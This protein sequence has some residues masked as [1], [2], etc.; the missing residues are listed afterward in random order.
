LLNR[1]LSFLHLIFPQSSVSSSTSTRI[2]TFHLV[3]LSEVFIQQ[4]CYRGTTSFFTF[5]NFQNISGKILTIDRDILC[6][7]LLDLGYWVKYSTTALQDTTS[8]ICSF[9]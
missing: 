3:T 8:Y 2:L 1:K 5:L 7:S 9:S 4:Q 6:E